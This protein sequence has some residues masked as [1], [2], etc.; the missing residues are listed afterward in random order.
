MALLENQ[1]KAILKAPSKKGLIGKAVSLERRVRFHTEANLNSSDIAQ[2]TFEFLDWVSKLIP[3]DKYQVFLELFKFPL[4]TTEVV[5]DVYRELER[6]FNSRNFAASYQ[7]VDRTLSDDWDKY[8]RNVL[9]EP[10]IWKKTGW[11]KMKTS[12]N[13]IL[14]VDLPSTQTSDRP[15]PYFYWLNISNVIDFS[16]DNGKELNWI[17]FK[18]DDDKIA[19]IDELSYRVFS[20]KNNEIVRLELQ[21][22]HSLGFCPARFFWSNQLTDNDK[23]LKKNPI[24]K[25]LSNL[26]WYLFF[27][28]SK[29]YLD[30]YAPYPIYSAYET[31]C[32]YENSESGEYCDGGFIKDAD[33]N[34][35]LHAGGEPHK[36]PVCSDRKIAGPGSF[37]QIPIPSVEDGVVDLKNPV[38]ITTIDRDSLDYN[39]KECERLKQNIISSIVGQNGN[40]S[41]KEAINTTQVSANFESKTSVLNNL[42]TNFEEA[43]KFIDDTICTLRYGEDFISSSINWGTEFY[44][45]SIR[46]LYEKYDTA[47]K[48]GMSQAE[49]DSIAN[50]ILEVEYK[51]NP[52]M[53][54][55]LIILKQLEPYRHYTVSEVLDMHQKGVLNKEKVILKVNFNDYVDKFERENTNIIDFGSLKPFDEK[56]SIIN[57]TLLDYV[58]REQLES[59]PTAGAAESRTSTAGS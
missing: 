26:D 16:T 56:I 8:K 44:V 34:Y 11:Q 38:Q 50:Q 23:E 2:P 35:I 43:Q 55:R 27:S 47:K 17:V 9:D 13:S 53:L 21:N 37:L 12:P 24:M 25:E 58:N 18:Q 57:K 15:E 33:D 3:R 1:I 5:E 31:E 41:E 14:V 49:L 29:Q 40:V 6:V 10:N 30:L 39:V 19:V 4:A 46:D 36:C 42:K 22:E 7:F 51:N 28:T 45:Y 20:V 48:A 32:D 54:Q 52:A 59:W